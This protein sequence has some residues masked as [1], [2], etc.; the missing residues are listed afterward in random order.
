M[1]GF[2]DRHVVPRIISRGCSQPPVMAMRR[3]VVPL[4]RGDVLELGAG[5][6]INLALYDRSAVRSVVGID[7]SDALRERAEAQ[8]RPAD[9][10]FFTIAQGVAE[11]LPFA[12]ARFDTVLSTFTLCSVDDQARALAEALRV[13][14]PD[15]QLLFLEHG[16]APD[17]GPARWQRRLEPAWARL[18]G[19]CHLTRPV[20]DAVTAAGFAVDRRNGRYIPK[21]PRFAGWVEWGSATPGHA[22]SRAPSRA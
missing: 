13:L 21:V 8:M 14:K 2:W 9:R 3:H 1:A 19:N 22:P 20:T 11:A 16:H 7:P 6:G 18:M 5:G 4:A 10:G 17:D 15:G 12:T